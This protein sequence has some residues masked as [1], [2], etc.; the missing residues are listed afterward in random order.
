MKT[1]TLTSSRT[2]EIMDLHKA[3]VGQRN[4][5]ALPKNI[6][7]Y[8]FMTGLAFLFMLPIFWM[9]STSLKLPREVFAFPMEWLPSN[10]Q[11]GNYEEAFSK[12]PLWRFMWNSTYMVVLS[13]I[14]QL[15]SVPLIAYGFARFEFPGKNILFMLMLATLMVPTHIKFIEEP[16]IKATIITPDQYLGSI[17]KM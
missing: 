2:Q 16:W 6:L 15:I 10:P 13:T 4:R 11:W 5:R 8:A 7:I 12:F 17:I 1:E 9:A 3:R 14:G